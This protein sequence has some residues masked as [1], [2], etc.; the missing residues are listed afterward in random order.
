MA[1]YCSRSVF[2]CLSLCPY[3]SCR[4]KWRLRLILAC[5]VSIYIKFEGQ[6]HRSK[7]TVT[8]G[9]SHSYL[10]LWF[11]SYQL[12]TSLFCCVNMGTQA[13]CCVVVWLCDN[14]PFVFNVIKFYLS[15]SFSIIPLLYCL[16]YYHLWWNK[17]FH[18][19]YRLNLHSCV[20][21]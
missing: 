11:R 12:Y 15:C 8:G 17:G 20:I 10:P 2:V 7:F 16:L 3:N 21:E 9:E 6:G 4:T 14:E 18:L 1:E 13:A 19:C 5:Q